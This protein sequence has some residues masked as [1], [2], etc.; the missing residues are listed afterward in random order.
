MQQNR[1]FIF[2]GVIIV[3]CLAVWMSVFVVYPRQQIAIKR[4]GQIVRVE[5]EPGL[6]F[7]TPFIDQTVIM[8]Y[9]P[10]TVSVNL[11][12]LCLMSVVL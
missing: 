1:F 4:F 3:I 11:K 5:Q 9:V 8:R 2:L 6:Y 10:F 12:P 7:K